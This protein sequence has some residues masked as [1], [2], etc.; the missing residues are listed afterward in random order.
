[1]PSLEEEIN[2]KKF[3]NEHQKLAVNILYTHG[4][5][6]SKYLKLLKKH[7]LTLSQYNVLRILR[8]QH[9][10]ASTINLL[11]E[12]MLDKTPDAS[13][14]VDRLIEKKLVKRN[15]CSADRRRVD[16]SITQQGLKVLSRLDFIDDAF[17]VVFKS[18]KRTEAKDLNNLLDKLRG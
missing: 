5:L 10:N 8:G 18:L 3:K 12:R 2:Q 7:S 11:K 17:K 6:F 16:V 4:W 9:P 1:M 13:R 15:T 14:L